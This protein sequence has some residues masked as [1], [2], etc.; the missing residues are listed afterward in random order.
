MC[1]DVETIFTRL[2]SIEHAFFVTN[3]PRLSIN[4]KCVTLARDGLCAWVHAHDVKCFNRMG[5]TGR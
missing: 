2:F 3:S 5:S 4:I 1:D